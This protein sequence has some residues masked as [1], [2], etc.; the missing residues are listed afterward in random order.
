M[1]EIKSIQNAKGVK[2]LDKLN[3]DER[4]L[5]AVALGAPARQVIL[6]AEEV[7]QST[8]WRDGYLSDE[9]GFQPPDTSEA[10][11]ALRN[12]P[13]RVWMDLCERMPGCIARGRVRESVA[14]LPIVEGSANIIPDKALWAALVALGML[15]SIYRYEERHDG[16]E[17]INVSTKPLRLDGVP[18]S[19]DLGDE[20][21]GI[22]R[23]IGLPYVQICIRMGRSIPHLTFFDQSSY[24]VD[25]ID[26]LSD[27]PYVGRFD[28]TVGTLSDL[29]N[30]ANVIQRLRWAMFG[31]GAERAF[32][33]G[34]ADT[35]A[36]FQHG[37][38]AI[39]ACQEHVMNRNNEGLLRELIRLKE[40]LERMPQAF[41]TI[42]LA[43]SGENYVSPA[44]WVR[45]A[46]FSAPLSKRCPATSGLQFPPYLVMDAFLGRKKY[47]SFLGAEGVHLRA[48]LPSNLR[49]FIAAI[50][51]HYSIPD[52]VKASGDPRLMG[53]FDGVVEAYTGERGFMGL[54]ECAGKTGRTETNG[55]SGATNDMRPWE[56]THHEFSA[57]MKERLEPFR[58]QRDLEP[59]EIRGTFEECRYRGRILSRNFVDS[60][61][62]RTIAM[63]TL[64]IQEAGIT[65][66]PGDRL[67]VMPMNSWTECAK[68]A[69]ALGLDS[70][71]EDTVTLDRVWS[72]YADHIASITRSGRPRLTVI[73]LLRKGHL[74][75]ITQELAT[76]LHTMLRASSNT[77]LQ[78]LAT[79]EWPVRASLGDLLQAA[80]Q[81]TPARIWD[82]AF[83][84]SG[85]LSWLADL[86]PVEVPRTYSIST[87]ADELLP[88]TVDLTIS[89]SN[90]ELC[91]TFAGNAKI[92][93]HGVSSGFLNPPVGD[94]LDVLDDEE[95]LLGVSRPFAFQLPFDDTSP[96]AL[97]AG[98]SGIAPF[99]SFWQARCGRT[100][101][102][103]ALYL[104]VQSREKFCYE[105]ELRQYVNEGLMEVHTAFSRDSRGLLYDPVT[106][107]LVEKEIPPRYIDGL[108]VEQG[109]SIC[110]LVMSK[111]Q[112]GI[113][114]Y[115]YVCGSVG[116]FDSVMSGIRK[117]L[118]NHR[119]PTMETVESILTTAFAERRFML[120]VFMTPKPLP[121]NQPTIPLSQLALHT[122]HK[123]DSRV[124]IS[125]HGKVY[126]V[127][128]FCSMHPGG[129]NIIKSNGGVD[130]S[131][132]FDL[133]AHTNNPEVSS[134]LTK[135]YI[136]ELTP[137][138]AYHSE[139]VGMLY[140]LWN[141][142]LRVATEQVVAS[143]FE[144]G[145]IME[146]SIVWFQG[147]LFN[148][149][150]VRRFYH[151]QSR[152]LQGA[153]S[154]LFGP[155]LQE[156]YLKIS[157]AFAN[158]ASSATP[159]K[160]PDVLGIIA[161][162]KGSSD[163]VKA[164]NEISQIGQ[165]TCNSES[166]R[167][168]EKGIIA[169][170][171]RSVQYDME[172]L[173]AIRDEACT[174]MDAFGTIMELDAASDSQRIAALSAFLMQVLERMAKRLEGFYTKL[175]RHSV[176]QPELERNPARARWNILKR[177]V[178]DGS[179][180]VLSRNV[181]I[182]AAPNYEPAV[183]ERVDFDQV[184][185]QIEMSLEHADLRSHRNLDLNEQHAARAMNTS[186]GAPA[187]EQHNQTNALKAMSSFINDNK[188]AI[189]RLSKLPQAINLEQLMQTYGSMPPIPNGLP[190]PP[191]SR[192]ASRSPSI[193][194]GRGNLA[195][196]NTV[197]D[198]QSM[199]GAAL[200][201]RHTAASEDNATTPT[202]I[203]PAA[204][205]SALMNKMNSR[206]KLG[207]TGLVSPPHSAIGSAQFTDRA[208]SLQRLPIREEQNARG[209][210][211]GNCAHALKKQHRE[212]ESV[213]ATG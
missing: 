147:E 193:T 56:Q 2:S 210:A 186:D 99:R 46:K 30:P 5:L 20:V 134:L 135:Y 170:A 154:A 39:A 139:E 69:A 169:Y 90:Y 162:A 97:F 196:R 122:G 203:S 155:K 4:D 187:Y 7:G 177:K 213:Q 192:S 158:A 47:D 201:R 142:F 208:R 44:E 33:K 17:G 148:M 89:R 159:S 125:V 189:R 111:K 140:D 81:D 110:D 83:D 179:F 194:G 119:S 84:L 86:I 64:D 79:N 61:P 107:D 156:M 178:R 95:L 65:F 104:G 54:L 127:T 10:P 94:E 93:R 114:G 144:V 183:G 24:N 50:E 70:T 91:S 9:Y 35:S 106:Q 121:C 1:D 152:L 38:D 58:G 165:F 75:P 31:D 185:S 188:R 42:S 62:T 157:F 108:I 3:V 164:S 176:F 19:D 146:S 212:P 126:D 200:Q 55:A 207:Q 197:T 161:R 172:F 136:G 129:T 29:Q 103:T 113:G 173:E 74:A 27:Y 77:V 131:K 191:S 6:R 182:S 48:W 124:W 57:S 143:H 43:G 118:Y 149:G 123:P 138:P 82:Q 63:V 168:H 167:H 175:A 211:N 52:Y 98:G 37:P 190:T 105:S 117:A 153:F 21:K 59:H 22:P 199:P 92:M 195:R 180:F 206:P 202:H 73:D 71:L 36:S 12:S 87:H 14:A 18:M 102:K 16:N 198:N 41:H 101:G 72:R 60:D 25:Y 171:Q 13:G 23:S 49:A 205:M 100:W 128:D 115:I 88:S 120:D 163:A 109:Q 40:I 133:L 80:V 26:P 132:S 78:V 68:V 150:G 130:C 66:Q 141:S 160:L 96:V 53:V 51:Y 45:W 116:V 184:V 204:T 85:N 209:F 32:L 67:A 76:K 151:Y 166:A 11:G 15:C 145:M 137:K 34:C 112:G 174:G 8:G 181:T 28:N